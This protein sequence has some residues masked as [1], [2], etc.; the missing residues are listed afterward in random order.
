MRTVQTYAMHH[1]SISVKR[2]AIAIVYRGWWAIARQ[3]V[4]GYF[5]CRIWLEGLS[6][7]GFREYG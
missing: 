6:G 1:P 7:K 3:L 4:A 5:N 2:S